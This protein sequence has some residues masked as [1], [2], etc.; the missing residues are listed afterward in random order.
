MYPVPNKH[1]SYPD[2][3]AESIEYKTRKE[4]AIVRLLQVGDNVWLYAS[5]VD[6]GNGGMAEPLEDRKMCNTRDEALGAALKHI[7]TYSKNCAPN[8]A[9]WAAQQ[10]VYLTAFGAGGRGV[11]PLQLSLFADDPSATIGGR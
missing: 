7:E 8:I 2:E 1:G 3:Q 11:I 10:S 9:K 6:Y 5:T 4:F